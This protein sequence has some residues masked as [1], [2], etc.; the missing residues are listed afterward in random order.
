VLLDARVVGAGGVEADDVPVA[1]GVHEERVVAVALEPGAA[2][3]RGA[4]RDRLRRGPVMVAVRAVE[5]GQTGR[6]ERVASVAG[7]GRVARE[8][9]LRLREALPRGTG[10]RAGIPVVA[11]GREVVDGAE[12]R[13]KGGG[14]RRRRGRRRGRGRH[15]R[16][17]RL[18][19]RRGGRGGR[20]RRRRRGGG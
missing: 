1:A 8:Q 15:G 13:G 14:R 18:C 4:D 9:R 2:L 6:G 5:A 20:R 7:D 11:R 3:V 10:A 12:R 16:G 19:R 17:G